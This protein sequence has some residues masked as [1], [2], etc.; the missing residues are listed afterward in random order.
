VRILLVEDDPVS[1]RVAS[2]ILAYL[3][4]RVGGAR[5]GAE[6]LVAARG[7]R[8]EAAVVDVGLPDADGF[9]LVAELRRLQPGLRCV[10][11]TGQFVPDAERRADRL[12]AG[13]LDKPVDYR[14]LA[15][16][17]GSSE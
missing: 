13:F 2:S 10:V 14:E 5:S 1:A 8:F 12:G 11:V 16:W 9:A 17:L 6:A 15:G 7:E 3:G 4:H